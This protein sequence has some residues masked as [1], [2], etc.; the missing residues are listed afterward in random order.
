VVSTRPTCMECLVFS[1]SL[2]PHLLFSLIHSYCVLGLWEGG[3]A[4]TRVGGGWEG[5][6]VTARVSVV[7]VVPRCC[8]RD[9]LT[10]PSHLRQGRCSVRFQCMF[11]LLPSYFES[12]GDAG[13]RLLNGCPEGWPLMR[14]QAEMTELMRFREGFIGLLGF[15]VV[16]GK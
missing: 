7:C 13:K 2:T 15:C 6:L 14:R 3:A 8:S 9:D 11:P 12:T 16:L 5:E 1:S 4:G 10:Y